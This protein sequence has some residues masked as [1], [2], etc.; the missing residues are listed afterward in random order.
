MSD[1]LNQVAESGAGKLYEANG[2]VVP[3]LSGTD[4][5]MG[6]QYG[7]LMVDHMQQTWDVLVEPGRTAGAI[8]DNDMATWTDRAMST[9]STRNR[10]F[11]LGVAEG[12]GWPIDKVGMLDQMMEFGV[13]QSKLHSFAGCTSI[14]SW[15]SHS[16]D[17]NTYVGRNMDWTPEFN[18]FAQVLTM[19]KPSDGSYRYATTGWPGMYGAFTALNEHGVYLDLHDGTSMGG[20]VVYTERPPVLNT[21]AD[22]MSETASLAAFVKR[23]NGVAQSVS[24]I[25][26]LADESGGVSMECSSMAGNRLRRPGGDSLVVVNTFL[27]PDWGLGKRETV[28]NSLRRFSNMTERLAEHAGSVDARVIRDLMD[29]RIFNEDGSF[30]ENGG[31]TKPTLQDADSTNYQTVFDVQRRQLWMKVPAPDHFADWTHFDLSA[32]W[33]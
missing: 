20:S 31:A 12:S 23:L 30:V 22:L 2:F 13:Y 4:R 27:N 5:E 6:A 11:V 26:T 7:A 14:A 21:Y 18:E 25:L 10:Q 8:T 29:L 28:S 1:Q 19:R 16:A 32:L 15:G 33:A 24:S 9:F 17:G 3:V